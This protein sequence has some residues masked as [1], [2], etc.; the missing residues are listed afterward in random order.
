MDSSLGKEM[1]IKSIVLCTALLALGAA[2]YIGFDLYAGMFGNGFALVRGEPI[3]SADG[4]RYHMA[5]F[6]ESLGVLLMLG[7][8]GLMLKILLLLKDKVP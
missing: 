6:G 3:T 4:F 8:A 7:C 5:M 1:V 2:I